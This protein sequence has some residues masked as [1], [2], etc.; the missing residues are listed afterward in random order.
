MTKKLNYLSTAII[1]LQAASLFAQDKA[2]S[3]TVTLGKK[4]VPLSQGVAYEAMIAEQETIVVVLAPQVITSEQLKKARAMEKEGNDGEFKKPYLKLLFEKTGKLRYW[5]AADSNTALGSRSD[6]A[7]T[8]EVK[9]DAG[10][11]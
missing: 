2:A 3:G 5:S 7:M 9:T 4:T 6:A 11:A 8:G 1:A 10:H